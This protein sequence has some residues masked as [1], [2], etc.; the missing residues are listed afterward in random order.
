MKKK[1]NNYISIG[2]SRKIRKYNI[3]QMRYYE[4]LKRRKCNESEYIATMRDENNIVEIEDLKTCFFTD[5][6]TVTSVNGVTFDIPKNKIVG[7]VGESGC[8][9][10]VT[11]L[12][13]MQ[14]VQAPQGQIVGG[15]IRMNTDRLGYDEN[16]KKTVLRHCKNAHERNV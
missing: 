9:K 11:S 1:D 16:G 12:S 2:E 14:L 4:K 15:S 13:I 5:N 10:S 7:I 3:K 8:G 6:G